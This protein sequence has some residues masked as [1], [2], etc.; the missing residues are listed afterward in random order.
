MQIVYSIW[1]I[2]MCK[3]KELAALCKA[4]KL[5]SNW[6]THHCVHLYWERMGYKMPQLSVN[7]VRFRELLESLISAPPPV[8]HPFILEK[9]LFCRYSNFPRIYGFSV[10]SCSAQPQPKTWFTFRDLIRKFMLSS[11][12]KLF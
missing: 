11:T 6:Q 4:N 2:L 3:N 8:C 12:W 10:P 9:P 5:T 1:G 7:T